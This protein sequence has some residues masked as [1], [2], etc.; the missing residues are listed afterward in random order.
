VESRATIPSDV[1][2][3]AIFYSGESTY[4]FQYRDFYHQEDR[5]HDA[6]GGIFG[7]Y[8]AISEEDFSVTHGRSSASINRP[9]RP[10]CEKPT[11]NS[12]EGKNHGAPKRT[13]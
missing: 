10:Q 4:S 3:E 8:F 6:L 12:A 2:R 7:R 9:D 1:L 11:T 5:I 13:D